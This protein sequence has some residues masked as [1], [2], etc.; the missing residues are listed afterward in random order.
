ME[1]MFQILAVVL[2]GA[3]AFFL[4]RSDTDAAFVTGV[5]GICAFFLSIRFQLKRRMAGR[6]AAA[7][8]S[9]ETDDKPENENVSA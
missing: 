9:N 8:M 4:W 7:E 6:E 3:T 5:L 2:I 1:R